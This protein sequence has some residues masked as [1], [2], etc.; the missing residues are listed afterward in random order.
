MHTWDANGNR[1]ACNF[2][3]MT[4]PSNRLAQPLRVCRR[5]A[6]PLWLVL[7]LLGL[8]VEGAAQNEA[9]APTPTGYDSVFGSGTDLVLTDAARFHVTLHTRGAGFGFQRGKFDGA[10]VERGWQGELVFVR[11]P[12]EEKTRNPIYEDGLPYVYG[13]VNAHHAA[14]VQRYRAEILAEKYRQN[15]VTVAKTSH[16]GV[17]LGVSK[18]IFLEIGYPE[19]PFSSVEVEQYDPEIH[20]SDRIYG[21]A[22]WVNGLESLGFNPGITWGQ[23]LSFEF[24]DERTVTRNLDVGVN[25]DIYVFPVEILAQEFVPPSRIQ[26]TFVLRYAWGAQWSSKG[27]KDALD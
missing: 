5:R 19:I 24:N 22:P 25:A 17:V 2:A 16:Y 11:H 3:S 8:D 23:G 18:P 14:R 4:S 7:G 15:G 26:F 27:L 21:R 9:S 13:K 12:K 10:F 20:F 1:A 6:L